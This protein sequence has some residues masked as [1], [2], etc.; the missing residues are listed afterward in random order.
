MRDIKMLFSC[1]LAPMLNP[2]CHVIG[3]YQL[4]FFII[5]Y[6]PIR[7]V[8][9]KIKVTWDVR[10]TCWD[11]CSTSKSSISQLQVINKY[12]YTYWLDKLFSMH[13]AFSP[14]FS[15]KFILFHDPQNW[16]CK[17]IYLNN[18]WYHYIKIYLF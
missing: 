7:R 9:I 1:C 15:C 12:V 17:V 6:Q 13:Y 10:I 4:Q 2:S 5:S 8:Q 11:Y 16:Q 14:P 3:H 18:N